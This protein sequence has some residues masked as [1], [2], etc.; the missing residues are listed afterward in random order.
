MH[1]PDLHDT[2]ASAHAVGSAVGDVGG[3]DGESVGD[4]HELKT[5]GSV[6]RKGELGS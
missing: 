4:G 1:C 5:V 6:N 2:D 3:D